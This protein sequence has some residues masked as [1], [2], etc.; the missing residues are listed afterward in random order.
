MLG[1][2]DGD[3][4]LVE[5]ANTERQIPARRAGVSDGCRRRF[6]K[7]RNFF[8][9]LRIMPASLPVPARNLNLHFLNDSAV[10]HVHDAIRGVK[11]S[12]IMRHHQDR[13][14]LLAYPIEQQSND[15]IS[16]FFIKG[17]GRFVG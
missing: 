6:G 11:N 8:A 13:C 5:L 2:S 17:G 16:P 1:G 7:A 9:A 10:N 14:L 15:L 3:L 4:V 12:G